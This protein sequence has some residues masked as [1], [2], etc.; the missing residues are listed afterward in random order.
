[1]MRG[2]INIRFIKHNLDKVEI[3]KVS[4]PVKL[5]RCVYRGAC[6]SSTHQVPSV[7][8]WD[9]SANRKSNAITTIDAPV[10]DGHDKASLFFGEYV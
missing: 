10:E 3:L 1:M 5:R 4:G 6:T 7:H 8:P 9:I 2:P